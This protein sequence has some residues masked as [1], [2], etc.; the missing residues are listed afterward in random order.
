M[1]RCIITMRH[2]SLGFRL[3][4]FTDKL[5]IASL[6]PDKTHGKDPGRRMP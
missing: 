6:C 4:S 3:C 1:D 2:K 5:R